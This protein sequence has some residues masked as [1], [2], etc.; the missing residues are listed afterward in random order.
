MPAAEERQFTEKTKGLQ[1]DLK[2]LEE[3][4]TKLTASSEEGS[5]EVEYED[6]PLKAPIHLS[7]LEN[8]VAN[9]AVGRWYRP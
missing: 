2:T 1:K 6:K 9:G 7:T 8:E 4:Y 3:E 5:E